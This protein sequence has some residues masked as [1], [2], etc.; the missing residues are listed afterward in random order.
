MNHSAQVGTVQ[1]L[2]KANHN[3]QQNIRCY[4]LRVVL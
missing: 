4:F 1:G 2:M 3:L